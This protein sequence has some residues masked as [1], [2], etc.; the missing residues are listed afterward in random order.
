[1]DTFYDMIDPDADPGAIDVIA[2]VTMFAEKEGGRHT[3]FFTGYSPNHNFGEADNRSMYVGRIY[4][5][6]GDSVAPGEKKE[7]RIRFL[8]AGD[9]EELLTPR[10]EWRIQEGL[11]LV[12]KGTVKTI[13]T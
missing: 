12:G 3:P 4:L 13:M 7:V 5:D 2:E 9:L 10:R 8:N 11:R 6:N 1:M